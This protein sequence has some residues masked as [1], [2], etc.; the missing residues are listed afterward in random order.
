M[1][2]MNMEMCY[3]PCNK[4]KTNK[5]KKQTEDAKAV[6]TR[7]MMMIWGVLAGHLMFLATILYNV[8]NIRRYNRELTSSFKS[9]DEPKDFI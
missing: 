1:A 2:K 4:I 7:M 9:K 5:R 6:A 3:V 8:I